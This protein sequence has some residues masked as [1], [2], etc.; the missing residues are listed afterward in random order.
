MWPRQPL[1]PRGRVPFYLS[2]NLLNMVQAGM[3]RHED[4]TLRI[5]Q[6]DCT[7]SGTPLH[8]ELDESEVEAGI[9]QIFTPWSDNE[10]LLM[11]RLFPNPDSLCLN[12]GRTGVFQWNHPNLLG[13]LRCVCQG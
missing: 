2:P 13:P 1:N 9:P 5:P 4:G 11:H 8:P 10:T 6:W 3:F 12:F 7:L